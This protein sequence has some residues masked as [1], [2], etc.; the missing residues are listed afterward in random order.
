MKIQTLD[1]PRKEMEEH[2]Y[3]PKFSGLTELGLEPTYMTDDVLCEMVSLL[4][5]GN[6]ILKNAEYYQ[7]VVELKVTDQLSNKVVFVTGATGTVGSTA[8]IEKLSQLADPP[9]GIIGVDNNEQAL[10]DADL[11]NKAGAR[12]VFRFVDIKEYNSFGRLWR[13]WTLLSTALR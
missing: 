3:N 12:V 10:F 4:C 5:L 13:G 6:Q 2:Y 9:R 1:N 8:I 7:S 11:R